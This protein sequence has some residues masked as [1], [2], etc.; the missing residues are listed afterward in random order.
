MRGEDLFP[1]DRS[2]VRPRDHSYCQLSRL[3]SPAHLARFAHL[4]HKKCGKETK[5]NTA[6][7]AGWFPGLFHYTK[8]AL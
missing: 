3:K 8:H 5:M 2:Y 6:D 1:V 4:W 7:Q